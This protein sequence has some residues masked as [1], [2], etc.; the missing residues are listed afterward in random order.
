M[1][2]ASVEEMGGASECVDDV[3]NGVDKQWEWVYT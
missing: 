2:E 1:I 3:G